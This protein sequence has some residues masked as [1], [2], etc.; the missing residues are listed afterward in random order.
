MRRLLIGVAG[1]IRQ[2]AMAE[3]LPVRFEP[4][5]RSANFVLDQL[6][7]VVLEGQFGDRNLVVLGPAGDEVVRL[8]TTCGTGLIDQVL[9][10]D[11]EIRVIEATPRGDFQARIDLDSFELVRVAEWR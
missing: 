5:A 10:I 1:T 9:D 4:P 3:G 11:G 7:L 2:V 8:G 6:A